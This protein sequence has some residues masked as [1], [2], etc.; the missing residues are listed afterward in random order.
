MSNTFTQDNLL[1]F[2]K[3]DPIEGYKILN[4][5]VPKYFQTKYP[6]DSFD[7]KKLTFTKNKIEILAKLEE[8]QSKSKSNKKGGASDVI[9]IYG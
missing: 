6:Y 7:T 9:K 2:S 8:S 5:I 1:N 4:T 3:F